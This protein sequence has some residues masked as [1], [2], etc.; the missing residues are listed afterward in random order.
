MTQKLKLVGK[1][2]KH[3]GK[4]RKCWLP[5]FSPFPTISSKALLFQRCQKSGLCGNELIHLQ[6][7]LTCV[8]RLTRG[9]P[10]AVGKFS[11]CQWNIVPYDSAC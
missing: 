8:S 5:A 9:K 7:V 1:G 11:D 6:K 3:C 2:K 10:F 4:R